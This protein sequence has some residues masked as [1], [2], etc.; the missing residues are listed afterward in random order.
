MEMGSSHLALAKVLSSAMLLSNLKDS[1]TS[2]GFQ[3]INFSE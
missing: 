3:K 1:S 2:L